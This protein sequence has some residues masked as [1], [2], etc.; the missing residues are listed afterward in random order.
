MAIVITLLAKILSPRFL[1]AEKLSAYECGFEPFMTARIKFDVSFALIAI[2][3]LVF[4]LEIIFLI[5]WALNII[6]L[7]LLGF[8]IMYV[9]LFILAIGFVFELMRKVL[10]WD[11][12]FI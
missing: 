2:L 4:D 12:I 6:Q 11:N 9:F 10:N 1:N 8:M 3:F 5:P 7:G